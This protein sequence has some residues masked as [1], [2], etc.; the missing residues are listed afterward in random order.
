MLLTVILKGLWQSSALSI[1]KKDFTHKDV[2]TF[3]FSQIECT[4][5]YH[6]NENKQGAV[7]YLERYGPITINYKLP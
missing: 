2:R 7:W 1:I 5:E 3:S 6:K 4:M